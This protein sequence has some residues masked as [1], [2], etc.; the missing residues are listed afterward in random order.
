MAP[1][2]QPPPPLTVTRPSQDFLGT[3]IAPEDEVAFLKQRVLALE[4][5]TR[6]LERL[7]L[8]SHVV[9]GLRSPSTQGPPEYSS[10]LD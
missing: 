3:E 7:A 4:I 8:E 10:Q 1:I 6:T 5:Q 2:R 9:D